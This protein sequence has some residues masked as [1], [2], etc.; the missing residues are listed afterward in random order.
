[1]LLAYLDLPDFLHS[2]ADKGRL[3]RIDAEVDPVLEITEITDRV[4]K[5]GGPAL[6]F[7]NVKGSQFPLVINTF[8]SEERM[9]LA[10]EVG[11][12]DEIAARIDEYLDLTHPAAGNFIDRLKALPKAAE[13][14]RFMPKKV[15]KGP[16]QEV[17]DQAPDL[18]SLPIL[19]CWPED[20]GRFLTL[21]L[22]FTKDPHTGWRNCGMYRMQ[23]YDAKTTGMHWH[24]HKDAARHFHKH[25]IQQKRM[26]A[27]VALGGDPAVIYAATAPL[28]ED[29]DEMFFAGFLRRQP[30]EMVRCKTVDIEVPAHAEFILEG[31]VDPKEQRLE[32]PFG[33]HT[34]YYSLSSQYPVFHV[35]CLTRKARPVYPAMVVGRPPMEDYFFGK[36]TERIFLPLL[37]L[38]AQ[39]IV[40]INMPVEG[41]F[42]NCV[43]VSIDKRYPGQA[44]KV[45]HAIWGAN[46]MMFTKLIIIVDAHVDV[47]DMSCVW[48]RV[49]NNFDP[50]RDVVIT[51]GPLDALDHASSLGGYGKKMGIDATKKWPSEGH[52]RAWPAELLME[53]RVIELVT[54]RWQEYGFN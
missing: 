43:V 31:Y 49:F 12:L 50:G 15:K 37:R 9:A 40:D 16:C 38:I 44:R 28:P 4:V 48:W 53:P 23:V 51:E 24:L 36:A 8:G 7:S 11:R 42:H 20:G 30:V 33:D 27:A 1:M 14:F 41:G 45:M 32:G 25:G 18:E 10:L 47:Q 6:L 46:Q 34:G 52:T 17:V 35:N 54:R 26:E 39:E 21:P 5:K 3:I 29:F 13:L 22:V 2:L 19:Q